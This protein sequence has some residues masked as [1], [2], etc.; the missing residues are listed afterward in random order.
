MKN[1][2]E[3]RLELRTG[4]TLSARYWPGTSAPVIALH[5]W[6]DN[7]ASF[8]GLAPR[9]GDLD[10]LAIDLPGHGRSSHRGRYHFL[11]YIEDLSQAASARG[12]ETFSL[13]GHSMGAA[14]S[15]LFAATFPERVERMVL[16]DGLT[17]STV[18]PKEA[19]GQL[20]RAIETRAR[21]MSKPS[22]PS[23][24]LDGLVE[25]MLSA[26]MPMRAEAARAI[27]QRASRSD[28]D[29]HHFIYDPLL[30]ASSM[31]RLTREHT[32]A[33]L[34]QISCPVLMLRAR[35]GWPLPPGYIEEAMASVPHLEIREVEGGHH[36]HADTPEVVAPHVRAF[37][38]SPGS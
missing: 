24:D 13:L 33:F 11:D 19:P 20:R 4:D 3:V 17:P 23:P 10:L 16:I 25:R 2:E 28:A 31:L 22:R 12:L 5:G 15:M 30:Q 29:G 14:V 26:R 34:S 27:A 21:A 8:D 37:L 9:L 38:M 32:R 35:D 6:L 36:V 18:A 1:V 7:A